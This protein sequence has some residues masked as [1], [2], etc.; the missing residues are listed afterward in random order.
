MKE[1]DY[2]NATNLAKARIANNVLVDILPMGDEQTKIRLEAIA[3]IGKLI[4]DLEKHVSSK[5]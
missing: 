4:Y 5:K 3:A 2:I 1:T